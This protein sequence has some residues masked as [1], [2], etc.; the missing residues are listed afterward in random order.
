MNQSVT[1]PGCA[2]A[3]EDLQI[4]ET[5]N[6]V[7]VFDARRRLFHFLNATAYSVL[8]SCNG[9]NSVRDIAVAISDQF[10]VEDFDSVAKD[11]TE[12]LVNFRDKG[13]VTD[14]VDDPGLLQAAAGTDAGGPLLAVAVSGSSMFPVLLSDDKVLVKKSRVEELAA[15][16]VVVWTNDSQQHIAHR[17]L[18]IDASAT[19][20]SI[21]TKGDL[22]LEPD[23]P[24]GIDRLLGKIVAVLRDGSIRWFAELDSQ[25]GNPAGGGGA[26]PARA[27]RASES[28]LPQRRPS[29]QRMQV[30]DL[31]DIP[32][33][34]IRNI[35]SVEEISLVLLSPRNADAWPGVPARDVKAVV[36]VPEDYKV[37][38][39]QPELLPEMLEFLDAP[40]RLVVSGQIFLTAFAPDQVRAAF[41]ELILNGQAYVGSDEAK[42]ALA[43]LTRILSGGIAVVPAEHTRWIGQ[44]ILGPEYLNNSEHRPLVAVGALTISERM[45][46][47]PDGLTLFNNLDGSNGLGA[48][49]GG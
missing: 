19:P 49:A 23:P 45:G 4:E 21:V 42:A 30:L 25:N 18:S 24:V 36:V 46:G 7:I 8:K 39:G 5:G 20:A 48:K 35:Q 17:L 41:A 22:C 6:E 14:V 43:P 32:A 44:S 13:L 9:T 28:A 31:R 1:S 26:D 16:D 40:L 11:V 3:S 10:N 29:Y 12:T 15:G 2:L 38:T 34:S 27:G 47:V 33:A 37:Y